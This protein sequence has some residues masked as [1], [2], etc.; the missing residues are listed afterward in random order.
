MIEIVVALCMFIQGEL[1]EHRVKNKMSD[2]LE[3][4]RTAE[5]NNGSDNIQYKCGK[6]KAEI[7]V[8]SQGY[9]HIENI[10]KE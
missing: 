4:K 2:C 10:I 1:V 7:S 3:G 5:R 9:K 8:D 6:V